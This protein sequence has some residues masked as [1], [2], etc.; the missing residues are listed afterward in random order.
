MQHGLYIY[1]FTFLGCSKKKVESILE[2]RPFESWTDLVRKFQISRQLTTDMLNS[3]T[4]LIKMRDAIAKLMEKCEKITN[5][6]TRQV[7]NLT[8]GDRSALELKEQ[9]K[10][11]NPDLKIT[12]YQLIG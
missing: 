10:I 8:N 6:M 5:K 4:I 12:G 2:L 1:I 3:A 11:M 7:E 9:P